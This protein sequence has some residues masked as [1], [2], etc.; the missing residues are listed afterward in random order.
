MTTKQ[1]TTVTITKDYT[2]DFYGKQ[3]IEAGRQYRVGGRGGNTLTDEGLIIVLGH[4]ADEL[5]PNEF[6]KVKQIEETTTVT[7]REV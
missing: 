2:F 3:T 4:G 6:I 5:I 7:T 1:F